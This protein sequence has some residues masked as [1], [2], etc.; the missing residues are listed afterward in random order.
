MS[1]IHVT[2]DAVEIHLSPAEKI[3]ALHGDL[4][5]P[6][7]AIRAAEVVEDGLPPPAGCAPRGWP[8]PAGSR[9][10]P[11][12]AGAR[13]SSSPSG[14]ASRRCAS[15]YTSNATTRFSFL[16]PTLPRSPPN[17][18]HLIERPGDQVLAMEQRS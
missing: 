8:F 3:G 11:G 5:V 16:R 18:S 13:L 15:R 7:R 6:R 12:G 4:R 10:A 14:G 2:G 1:T 9:S 17:C